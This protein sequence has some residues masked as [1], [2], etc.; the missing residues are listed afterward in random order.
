MLGMFSGAHRMTDSLSTSTEKGAAF[1]QS[2]KSS[3][4]ANGSLNFA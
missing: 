3:I 1:R 2:G 4:C